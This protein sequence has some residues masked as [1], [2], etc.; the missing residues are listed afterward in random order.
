MSVQ[1]RS[2]LE[3]QWKEPLHWLAHSYLRD[4][5]IDATIAVGHDNE[6]WRV[7]AI[8]QLGSRLPQQIHIDG[9]PTIQELRSER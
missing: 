5:L 8:P 7:T 6:G 4:D 9:I 3:S 1:P 2:D